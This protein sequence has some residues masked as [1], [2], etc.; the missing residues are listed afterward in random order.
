M[1][2]GALMGVVRLSLGGRVGVGTL[3]LPPPPPVHLRNPSRARSGWNLGWRG[4]GG[5]GEDQGI[6]GPPSI[7][8]PLARPEKIVPG[9]G[10]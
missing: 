1:G 4:G 3:Y 10:G 2:T 7:P 9:E 8:L 6:V 5:G